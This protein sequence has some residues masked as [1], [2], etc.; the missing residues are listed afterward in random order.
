[1]VQFLS[2]FF[3]LDFFHFCWVFQK[4]PFFCVTLYFGANKQT[5]ADDCETTSCTLCWCLISVLTMTCPEH[6]NVTPGNPLHRSYDTNHLKRKKT[7]HFPHKMY[8]P[9]SYDSE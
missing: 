1:M 4:F 9:A 6:R 5:P 7:V 8:L 3:F 2:I